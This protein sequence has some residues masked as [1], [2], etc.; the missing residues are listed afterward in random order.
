MEMDR[1]REFYNFLYNDPYNYFNRY[2]PLWEAL[3]DH[4]KQCWQEALEQ[5]CKETTNTQ[6]DVTQDNREREPRPGADQLG[7]QSQEES[8]ST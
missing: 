4:A 3:P 6:N 7:R 2:F 5:V 8:E 1:V